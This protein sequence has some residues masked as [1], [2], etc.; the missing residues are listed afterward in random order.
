MSELHSKRIKDIT[1]KKY[2]KLTALSFVGVHPLKKKARWLCRCD[3][4]NMTTVEGRL[5][6]GRN[7]TKSCGCL[8][9]EMNRLVKRNRKGMK[10]T[11]GEAG[12]SPDG[13]TTEYVTWLS[14]R[15]RCNDKNHTNYKN[16]GN[17]GIT[18]C[19]EWN[20]SFEHFLEDMGRKPDAQ[21]SIDRIDPNKGYFK[22]NCRW[23]S[24]KTQQNN[25]TNNSSV[26]CY[27]KIMTPAEASDLLSIPPR[28]VY[29]WSKKVGDCGDITYLAERRISS[30]PR[31]KK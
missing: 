4:G 6:S 19:D 2:G 29:H 28:T 31:I 10:L 14:M 18:V 22:E 13:R 11:H 7:G 9:A 27:G 16:Y 3:C 20:G 30:R 26:L 1:G 8:V 5:L 25:K 23:A 24:C 12:H 21:Y 17:R 15:Q